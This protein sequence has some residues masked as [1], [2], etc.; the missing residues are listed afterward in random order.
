MRIPAAIRHYTAI[1]LTVQPRV[2]KR[3]DRISCRILGICR[4]SFHH[5]WHCRGIICVP[6]LSR[7]GSSLSRSQWHSTAEGPGPGPACPAQILHHAEASCPGR[8]A[9]GTFPAEHDRL[10]VPSSAHVPNRG[11]SRWYIDLPVNPATA[12][13]TVPDTRS[14]MPEPRSLS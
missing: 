10:D 12:P 11:S 9:P 14:L 6:C 4:Y 1:D 5:R 3:V 8:V 2:I 13:P 7:S